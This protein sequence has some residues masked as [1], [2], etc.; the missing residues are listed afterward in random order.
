MAHNETQSGLRGTSTNHRGR[1]CKCNDANPREAIIA[2]AIKLFRKKGYADTSLGEIARHINM[3]PSSLYYYFPSKQALLEATTHPE[4]LAPSLSCLTPY[5]SQASHQLY[6]LIIH[7][8]VH[9]CELPIDFLEM[10]ALAHKA[11]QDFAPFFKHYE[12]GYTNMITVI[13]NGIAS[14]E[15]KP[16]EADEH[17][18]TILSINEGLQHHYHAKHRNQLILQTS[19]YTVRNYIPSEI[20]HLSARCVLPALMIDNSSENI[21][22]VAREGMKL[23]R[24]LAKSLKKDSEQNDA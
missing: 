2:I 20:G 12:A 13:N 23:Y 19:G 24:Q 7:D 15:F 16:C 17:A 1:P 18:V 6:A 21:E 3:D 14:G 4:H 9:K 8:V 22:R 10:E 5:S 11:P